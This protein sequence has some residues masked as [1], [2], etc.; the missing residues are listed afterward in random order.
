MTRLKALLACSR[1]V[2][3]GLL[4]AAAA[5]C[6]MLAMAH[7][8]ATVEGPIAITAESQ[9]YRGANEQPVAGHGLGLPVLEPYGY[10]EEEYFVSG[11]VG[12]KPYNTSLLV[13]KPKDPAKFSGLVA[14]ETIHAAGA[15]PLWG[16][17]DIWLPN[18][19]AWVAV[20]SQ[21]S[22]LEV[23]VKKSNPARY[24]AL[25]IPEASVPPEGQTSNPIADGPQD[26]ISQ[27]IMTQ[28]GALLKSHAKSGPFKGMIVKYLLMGGS[29]QTGGTT[30]RYIQE[31]HATARLPD[32]KP[33][34]DAYLPMEAFTAKPLTGG[35][36]VV[37]HPVGEGDLM[38]FTAMGRPLMIRGDS[39][40]PNDRYRHYQ[41]VGAAHVGTRGI[42]DPKVIFATLENAMKPGDQLS[43]FPANEVYKAAVS[44]LIDWVMKGIAPPKA[45]RIEM[46]NGQ[47]VRD[48]FGN[49]KGGVR[50]PYVDVP[51]V[52]YIASAPADERNMMRRLIG[53]QEP[54]PTEKL[55]EMYKTRENYLK[56][57]NAGIDKMVKERWLLPADGEK[58][59]REEAANP[60]F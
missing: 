51:T 26:A 60:P 10:V 46:V 57:F 7:T 11:T 13:R 53:L 31:S 15:I 5:T 40:E 17:R 47:I 52:R 35:D 48:E 25:S 54:I 39:D 4:A 3:A 16:F 28:V 38:F 23:H 9:P 19:H 49:A 56:L 27:Q 44:N 21:R 33:I 8:A 58:L 12:G 55:R 1:P 24:A 22:A 59:K 50:S 43:Q 6:S 29:S 45:P 14:V 32:G 18:G 42:S 41:F 20:A 34:Y 30:L 36:A 37:M 2:A